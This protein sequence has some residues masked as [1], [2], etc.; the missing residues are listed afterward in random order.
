MKVK[1]QKRRLFRNEL[2]E[3][4]CR[5]YCLLITRI[6]TNKKINLKII[7]ADSGYSWAKNKKSSVKIKPPSPHC[8]PNLAETVFITIKVSG[9]FCPDGGIFLPKTLW[10]KK[11][12]IDFQTIRLMNFFVL[13]DFRKTSASRIFQFRAV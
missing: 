7:R 10:K 2:S 5:K 6:N 1:C 13:T 8:P 12:Q 4:F 3:M 11:P 9:E